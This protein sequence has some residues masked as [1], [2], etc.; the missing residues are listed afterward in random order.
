MCKYECY[1]KTCNNILQVI[2]KYCLFWTLSLLVLA[3]HVASYLFWLLPKQYLQLHQEKFETLFSYN[4][5]MKWILWKIKFYSYIFSVRFDGVIFYQED[6]WTFDS[7]IIFEE[8]SLKMFSF[9]HSK[10]SVILIIILW[11][12]W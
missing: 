8:K 9:Y 3:S 12:F 1:M 2:V 5:N 4:E 6:T 10:I 7:P 11:L